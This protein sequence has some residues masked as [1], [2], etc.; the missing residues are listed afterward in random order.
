MFKLVDDPA[1]LVFFSF[2]IPFAFSLHRL[3]LADF[4]KY[5]G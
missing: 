2:D 3:L 1:R 5:I 4:K